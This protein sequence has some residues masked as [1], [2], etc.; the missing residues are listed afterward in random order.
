MQS[1]RSPIVV[2]LATDYFGL[3][4]SKI[5]KILITSFLIKKTRHFLPLAS[6]LAVGNINVYANEML[7]ITCSASSFLKLT[8]LKCKIKIKLT[9]LYGARIFTAYVSNAFN[10]DS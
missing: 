1:V 4:F 7:E 9:H 10:N 3:P 6:M 2:A 8:A 5:A